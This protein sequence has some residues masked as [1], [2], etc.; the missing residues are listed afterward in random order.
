MYD[1]T[2][3][4]A[5]NSVLHILPNR[6]WRHKEK[7]YLIAIYH[8]KI[9]TSLRMYF[10]APSRVLKSLSDLHAL[11]HGKYVSMKNGK[12]L[13]HQLFVLVPTLMTAASLSPSQSQW[14]ST[15]TEGWP[16]FHCVPC[17]RNKNVSS[18]LTAKVSITVDVWESAKCKL[19][20]R[21]WVDFTPRDSWLIV[22]CN[23]RL[24]TMDLEVHKKN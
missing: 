8:T 4:F 13:K 1:L 11:A 9:Y 24:N 12:L 6:L 19:I 3:G 2:F 18:A 5:F 7:N 20:E 16:A 10:K 22:T 15:A 23:Y 21:T 14:P 17:P